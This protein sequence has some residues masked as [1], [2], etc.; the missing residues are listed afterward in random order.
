MK[1]VKSEK[2]KTKIA[3]T[4]APSMPSPV[5]LNAGRVWNKVRPMKKPRSTINKFN[6]GGEKKYN[7]K[8]KFAEGVPDDK[9]IKRGYYS[10]D[11]KVQKGRGG[12]SDSAHTTY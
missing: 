10:P 9:N 1:T 4:P 5:P 8:P 3:R 2:N 7:M 6:D 12:A 11:A